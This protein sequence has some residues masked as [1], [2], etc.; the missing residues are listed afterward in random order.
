MSASPQPQPLA[1]RRILIVDD[2]PSIRGVL[3]VALQEAGAE[4]WTAPDGRLALDLLSSNV[5]DLIL[6]DLSMPNMDGWE[7]I[8]AIRTLPRV[9]GIPVILETSSEDY[10]SFDRAKKLGVAAFISKP[11]RLVELI[12]TCRRTIDGA[13]PLQGKLSGPEAKGSPIQLLDIG[14]NVFATGWLLD[15]DA[16]G[17]QIDLGA[18]LSLS[19]SVRL[20]LQGRNGVETLEAEVRWVTRAGDRYHHGLL[21][22]RA[23]Q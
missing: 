13:R 21:F 4:V 7:V 23:G 1:S 16:T 18:P 20:S 15:R 19:Q 12:E 22:R 14:G 3:E 17:A 5:P 9:S 8:E 11:F 6:L 2:Q 10:P